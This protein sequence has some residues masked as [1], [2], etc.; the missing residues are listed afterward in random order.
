MEAKGC[1]KPLVWKDARRYFYWALR[2]RLAKSSALA[3]LEEAAPDSSREYRNDLLCQLSKLDES[4]NNQAIATAFEALDL[5]TT[6]TRLKTEQLVRKITEM[7][8]E[9]RK[10]TMAGLL[11]FVDNLDDEEKGALRAALQG[12]KTSPAPP[13]YGAAEATA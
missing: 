13:A 2:A 9:D 5:A 3:E 12:S 11:R 6:V 1:A 4:A 7:V 10:A 8:H